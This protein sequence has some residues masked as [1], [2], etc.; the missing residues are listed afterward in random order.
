MVLLEGLFGNLL[1]NLTCSF[2]SNRS[3]CSWIVREGKWIPVGVRIRNGTFA[4]QKVSG[5][6]IV[7]LRWKIISWTLF[8]EHC[9]KRYKLTNNIIIQGCYKVMH[10][11]NQ[12]TTPPVFLSVSINKWLYSKII[13]ISQNKTSEVLHSITSLWKCDCMDYYNFNAEIIYFI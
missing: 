8:L 3:E 11:M 13:F 9:W 4:G 5:P 7:L 2:T 6:P 12:L 1:S 10:K